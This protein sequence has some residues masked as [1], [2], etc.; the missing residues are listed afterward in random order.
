MTWVFISFPLICNET[1]KCNNHLPP[2]ASCFSWNQLF[3]YI[4]GL[5]QNWTFNN[6]PNQIKW[7][8]KLFPTCA[9]SWFT[10]RVVTVPFIF[11]FRNYL[12]RYKSFDISNSVT[13]IHSLLLNS[14]WIWRIF[15][16]FRL[17]LYCGTETIN[18]KYIWWNSSYFFKRVLLESV[19]CNLRVIGI[20]W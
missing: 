12:F 6:V 3:K 19:K 10:L 14:I 17:F 2:I 18:F 13:P 5:K 8:T 11:S 9:I 4:V 1:C 20:L 7:Y 16:F 15:E